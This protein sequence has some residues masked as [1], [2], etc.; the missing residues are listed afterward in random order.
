MKIFQ[1]LAYPR[2]FPPWALRKHTLLDG[3]EWR[4]VGQTITG[5]SPKSHWKMFFI[6]QDRQSTLSASLAWPSSST[7]PMARGLKHIFHTPF[8]PGLAAPNNGTLTTLRIP[9]YRRSQL[10]AATPLSNRSVADYPFF[11]MVL[12]DASRLTVQFNISL[13]IRRHTF[14]RCCTRG[15]IWCL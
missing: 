8:S 12:L 13:H 15:I 3:G 7:I 14:L 1:L 4:S 5:T 2:V 6:F 10:T 9:T 11:E